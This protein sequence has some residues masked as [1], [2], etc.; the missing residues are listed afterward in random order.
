MRGGGGGPKTKSINQS[1]PKTVST[2]QSAKRLTVCPSAGRTRVAGCLDAHGP[3]MPQVHRV[4][5]SRR[6]GPESD[7]GSSPP[8]S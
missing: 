5:G 1:D 3:A 2:M 6:A 4:G 8:A 7:D